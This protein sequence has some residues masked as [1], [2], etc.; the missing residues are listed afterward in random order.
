[1]KNLLVAVN[2]KYIHTCLATRCLVRYV[3]RPDTGML[4]YTI[5]ESIESVTASVYRQAPEAVLF[6]CYIWNIDF[7][8][9][10]ADDIKKVLPKAQ[11]VLGGPQVSFDAAEILEKYPFV[12][13][14]IRGEGEETLKQWLERDRDPEGVAGMTYRDNAGNIIEEPDRPLIC[15]LDNLPF[16]WTEEDI[17]RNKHKLVYY[18]S[19][20]GCPFRCSY[21][22]SST[23]HSV[24]LRSLEKVRKELLFFVRHGVRIVKFVDRTFNADRKRTYELLQFLKEHGGETTFHFEVAADLLTSEQI[25]LL[26]DAPKGLFQLEIGVQSTNEQTLEAIDRKT[27]LQKIEKAVRALQ[28]NRN[29]H[30]HL[31]LIAGL[32]YEDFNSFK[33]S[34][35]QVLLWQPEVLQLGF[36][37]ILP[38]TKIKSQSAAFS[39]Q[40]TS[41]PPFEVLENSFITYGEMRVLKRVEAALERYYNSGVFETA[42][43][44]LLSK[45]NSAFALFDEIGLFFEQRGYDTVGVSRKQ[46]YQILSEFDS[47]SLLRDYLKLDYF[48]HQPGSPTPAWSLVPYDSS[49]NRRRFDVLNEEFLQRQL[50]EYAGKPV[51]EIV[52]HLH[53]ERFCYDVLGN[54]EQKEQI[55]IF[56]SLYG[57]VA[58][59]DGG[60]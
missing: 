53:F 43:R 45:W 2:A 40:Y 51:K 34:F 11:I 58:V 44:Y 13:A 10:V 42:M 37:K 46:L 48:L 27:N 1:M 6:S 25:A 29:V 50:P 28:K 5:N 20:R 56:D 16:A 49:W 31:D 36:L 23:V 24:R 9:A 57:K 22:L 8:L 60:I 14:V 4:E 52:K 47:D 59:L 32:P 15:D 12:D 55:L 17:L 30:L 41:R 33:H 26:Q 38:G 54:G 21:C 7:V 18:E 35:D 39:Y 3:N 19:S